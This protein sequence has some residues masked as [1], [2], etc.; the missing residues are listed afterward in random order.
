[1]TSIH[2]LPPIS[3]WMDKNQT[4]D[5]M[6][7]EKVNN[8]HYKACRLCE[9]YRTFIVICVI[10]I[11]I[12]SIAAM[13]L[14]KSNNAILFPCYY[15]TEST[16]ASE[17]S[18]ACVLY[19]WNVAQCSTTLQSNP[20]WRWWIQSP[21]GLTMIKCNAVYKDTLCGAGSYATIR[22]YIQ[23]CNSHYGQ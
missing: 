5:E 22:N 7:T 1:M 13:I 8:V 12:G 20:T 9:R 15:Y 16:L 10:C 4:I 23:L 11:C 3:V 14:L 18:E 6:I 17:V 19:L 2:P 21:Q